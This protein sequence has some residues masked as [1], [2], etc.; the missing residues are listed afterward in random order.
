MQS[1][2][3]VV[4][5]GPAG[6]ALALSLTGVGLQVVVV[7]TLSEE[8][9]ADPPYDGRDIALTHGSKR[10]LTDLGIWKSLPE[11]EIFPI[12]DAKV[13]DGNSSYSLN[14]NRQEARVDAL[15]FLVSNHLIRRTLY[16][17]VSESGETLLRSGQTVTSVD[18]SPESISVTLSNGETLEASLLIAADSRFS[19]VR[20]R[21]GIP[22]RTRDFGRAAVICRMSHTEHNKGVASECFQ[23]GQTVAVLPLTNNTS[24]IV[25]TIRSERAQKI[26][27]MTEDLFEQWVTTRLDGK[28]GKM[29]LTTK[30]F[31][32][33]LVA[34]L[35][36]RFSGSRTA[37]VGDAAVGMHPVTAH[38]YNLGLSGQHLLARAVE[39]AFGRGEDI[40]AENLLRKYSAQHRRVVLPMYYGT[41]TLVG[42]YTSEDTPTKIL[43]KVVLHAANHLQPMRKIV[44]NRLV[45]R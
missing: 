38:G 35:A 44:I 16:E 7:E 32:Y 4:G 40:G 13:L 36:D 1:D 23:Y 26:A 22:A 28:F 42:L 30:R 34:V 20:R 33:P 45:G 24:S 6:L 12:H 27:E 5:A 10:I 18:P 14:F 29:K 21:V 25:I 15:G 2:L 11:E 8:V 39:S 17:A 31:L 3:I 37:L 19:S 43:R 41:N 9:L